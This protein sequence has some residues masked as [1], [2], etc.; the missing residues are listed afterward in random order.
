MSLKLH[1]LHFR[2]DPPPPEN[3]GAMSNEYGE[4]ISQMEKIHSGK[5]NFQYVG[6]LLLE[7]SKGDT[8]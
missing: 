6:W 7:C 1:F 8:K 3:M 2:M 4:R 5:W